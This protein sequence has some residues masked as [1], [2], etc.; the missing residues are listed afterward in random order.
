MTEP[1]SHT[2]DAMRILLRRAWNAAQWGAS[3]TA[4]LVLVSIVIRGSRDGS[5]SPDYNTL[6]GYVMTFIILTILMG[7]V[8][9]VTNLAINGLRYRLARDPVR[10]LVT[11]EDH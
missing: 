9:G 1:G 11:L 10:F 5:F 7:A 4:V 3:L 6:V 2:E 8:T